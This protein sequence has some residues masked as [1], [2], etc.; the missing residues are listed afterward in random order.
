MEIL[1]APLLAVLVVLALV[2]LVSFPFL[3]LKNSIIGAVMLYIGNFLGLFA[4]KLTF[5]NCLIA[6]VLGIP[7][8]ILLLIYTHFFK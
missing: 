6:G 7:G 2:K 1:V 8:V 5:L 4:L 3:L